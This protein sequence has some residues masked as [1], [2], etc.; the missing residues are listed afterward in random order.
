[1]VLPGAVPAEVAAAAAALRGLAPPRA[2]A[3]AGAAL[4]PEARQKAPRGVVGRDAAAALAPPPPRG[5]PRPIDVAAEAREAE[6]TEKPRPPAQEAHPIVPGRK[7]SP[8]PAPAQLLPAPAQ[9]PRA[10]ASPAP[11]PAAA[12][13][14]ASPARPAAEGGDVEGAVLR[15]AAHL[16]IDS[17]QPGVGEI[18]L[19]LR[20]RE[21]VAHLR[22]DGEGGHLVAARA[23]EL[24]A[25]LA[26]AGLSLGRLETP[27]PSAVA[28]PPPSAAPDGRTGS[29]SGLGGSA[30]SGAAPHGQP[31]SRQP[32]GHPGLG[33]PDARRDP[34]ERGA[35]AAPIPHRTSQGHRAP[36]ASRSRIHVEA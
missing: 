13:P 30:G 2:K 8:L 16:R 25:A 12:L 24:A 5:A 26:G 28:A 7:E 4:S 36:A 33:E 21:G 17:G 3:E 6:R 35:P 31:G 20:V 19:H 32:G 10:A 14:R 27:P 15:N 22:V 34:R 23:P 1:M 9:P 11:E 18:E 29:E